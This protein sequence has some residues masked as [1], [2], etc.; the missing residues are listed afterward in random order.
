MM[1][2]QRFTRIEILFAAAKLLISFCTIMLLS[3]PSVPV[4]ADKRGAHRPVDVKWALEIKPH[5]SL[6][7]KHSQQQAETRQPGCPPSPG[8]ERVWDCFLGRSLGQADTDRESDSGSRKVNVGQVAT[9]PP[10]YEFYRK[11]CCHCSS[12]RL[13]VI[14][15]SAADMQ[16]GK[17][18]DYQRLFVMLGI[19][20][21]SLM[22]QRGNWLLSAWFVWETQVGQ[23]DISI[24]LLSK[25]NVTFQCN[26]DAEEEKI[27]S[28]ILFHKKN[29]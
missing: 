14:C 29:N 6:S 20:R 5:L 26:P 2:P 21:R 3:L 7:L 28:F 17:G 4:R 27:V 16:L 23:L 11:H 1:R 15:C 22:E 12:G 10:S 8:A 13:F 24:I 19:R 25:N 9:S 18:G